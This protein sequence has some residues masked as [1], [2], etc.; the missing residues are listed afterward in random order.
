MTDVHTFPD[1]DWLSCLLLFQLTQ[2]AWSSGKMWGL[3]ELWALFVEVKSLMNRAAERALIN[4]L[5][6]V[7][8]EGPGVG[9]PKTPALRTFFFF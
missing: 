7:G 5:T 3:T 2:P 9:S 8:E 6:V 1:P 4:Y